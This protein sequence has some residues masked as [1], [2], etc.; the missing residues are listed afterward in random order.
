MT[1]EL[2]NCYTPLRVW[3]NRPLTVSQT[4]YQPLELN[5]T[6]TW[7]P[8]KTKALSRQTTIVTLYVCLWST[9][10]MVLSGTKLKQFATTSLTSRLHPFCLKLRM[11]RQVIRPVLYDE[12]YWNVDLKDSTTFYEEGYLVSTTRIA[13]QEPV[14]EGFQDSAISFEAPEEIPFA[15]AS[16]TDYDAFESRTPVFKW[17]M[18]RTLFSLW[19]KSV[20]TFWLCDRMISH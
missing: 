11:I 16:V 6:I 18:E 3:K 8:M 9:P 15:Y 13:E 5:S 4:L 20:S 19:N 10:E 2:A 17:R 1:P 7:L 12:E 14:Q